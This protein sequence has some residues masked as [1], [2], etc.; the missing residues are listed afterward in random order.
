MYTISKN[1]YDMNKKIT[2]IAAAL[3]ILSMGQPMFFGTLAVSTKTILLPASKV[4]AGI[5]EDILSNMNRAYDSSSVGQHKDAIRFA[6]KVIKLLPQ[7]GP[8]M[9]ESE[10]AY[11]MYSVR[12]WSKYEIDDIKGACADWRKEVSLSNKLGDGFETDANDF[13]RDEC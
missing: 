3:S 4:N 9:A 2:S 7:M 5:Q 10:F 8:G 11:Y 1:K 6:T 13:I 12:A